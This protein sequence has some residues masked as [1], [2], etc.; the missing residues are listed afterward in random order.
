MDAEMVSA[1]LG[2]GV[3]PICQGVVKLFKG[4][5]N[6]KWVEIGVGRLVW[7]MEQRTGVQWFKLLN[8]ENGNTLMDEELYDNFGDTY[9]SLKTSRGTHSFHIFEFDE[10]IGACFDKTAEANEFIKKIPVMAPKSAKKVN[11]KDDAR[12][13]KE[14]K[15]R[16]NF[17][18]KQAKARDKLNKE[19]GGGEEGEL[20]GVEE[21]CCE[22]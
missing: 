19:K 9:Q 10:V 22:H 8:M 20:E 3:V 21:S 2:A 1:A 6:K 14:A 4:E 5:N 12:K 15:D 7:C 13:E 16:Y 11:S 17:E 18:M